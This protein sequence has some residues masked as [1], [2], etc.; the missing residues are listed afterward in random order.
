MTK[1]QHLVRTHAW[2]V[3]LAVCTLFT[4]AYVLVA[5]LRGQP[6]LMN[7]L[8]FSGVVAVLA[9]MRIYQP[10]ARA[11]W[12]CFA[13]G[14]TLQLAGDVYTYSLRELAHVNVPFPSVGDAMYLLV[15]PL[16]MCGLLLLVRSRN[17]GADGPG[18]IDSLIISLGLGLILAT[19]LLTPYLHDHS[20]P[21]VPKLVSIAY[22][23]GDIMLLG[24][25]IRLAVDTGKR[26]PSFYLVIASIVTLLITDYVYGVLTF[27]NAYHHQFW[28]DSGWIF[29]YVFWGAGALHPSMNSLSDAGIERAPRLGPVRLAMLAT[30]TLI[31]PV[32]EY[33]NARSRHDPDL[34][35]VIVASMVLFALVV[36]RMA[37]LVR[38]RERAAA[39]ER[40]LNATGE[41]LVAATSLA[42]IAAAGLAAVRALAGEEYRAFVCR[43]HGPESQVARLDT[44]GELV[45]W[46]APVEL[47]EF[48]GDVAGGQ[49]KALPSHVAEQLHL[50]TADDVIVALGTQ[51]DGLGWLMVT[52]SQAPDVESRSSLAVLAHQ[53]Q[54]AVER[55]QLSEKAHRAASEQRLSSLVRHSSDLIT[56]ID[57]SS[58]IIYQS[59]SIEAVLGYDAE[60][61]T[62]RPFASLLHPSEQGRLPICLADGSWATAAGEPMECV[63]AA[64]DGSPRS[65]EVLLND[66]RDDEHVR[67]IVLNGRDVSERKAFEEQLTH[68]AFHDSVT[69]LANRAL[70][71]ERVRHAVARARREP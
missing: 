31:A 65:F 4:G 8:G 39:R 49:P 55:T 24:A 64:P 28:L 36:G 50:E 3:Y 10:R 16:L 25:A 15:Y 29:L 43:L 45:A 13:A 33:I 6:V 26:R 68:Q 60:E 69:H 70:F 66:L 21:L 19:Q 58:T 47:A 67:G 57:E 59:P 5:P 1:R 44:S 63:L 51:S 41:R 12:F 34:V 18:L 61:V 52:G 37:G 48:L 56:V 9:G 40:S 54:L 14:L 22:P 42:D 23:V 7:A 27:H 2:W 30:A 20:M 53:I 46:G 17:R 71:N 62:G 35:F 38:Q 32:L 11:A